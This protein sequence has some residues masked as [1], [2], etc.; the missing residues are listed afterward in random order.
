M[1]VASEEA[2]S[3]SVIAKAD[4]IWPSISGCSH[5]DFCSGVPNM[6]STSMLPVFGASQ[7]IASGA[8]CEDQPVISATAAY[9]TLVRPDTSGRN[10]FHSPRERASTFSSSTTG[11]RVWSSRPFSRRCS[12][13]STS[14]GRMRVSR[15]SCMRS[16]RSCVLAEWSKSTA[17][18]SI[19]GAV[20]PP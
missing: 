9:S 11:G 4:R 3:G 15:K 7:L 18:P 8:M 12:S 5:C 19:R 17:E 1:F 6:C 13:Y 2:T 20:L 16:S 14:A 10:R